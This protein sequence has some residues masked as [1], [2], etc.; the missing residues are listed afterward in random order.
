MSSEVLCAFPG[1][2]GLRAVKRPQVMLRVAAQEA[3]L[4]LFGA[5][6]TLEQIE[7]GR[8]TDVA[9]RQG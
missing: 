7:N 4:T 8:E 6:G 1:R 3:R 2:E 5:F 9:E